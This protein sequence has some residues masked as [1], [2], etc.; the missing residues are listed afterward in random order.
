MGVAV[1][2][3]SKVAQ[4]FLLADAASSLVVAVL[5]APPTPSVSAG[6][7]APRPCGSW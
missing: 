5:R 6:R 4:R 1:E 3:A 2:V 7:N